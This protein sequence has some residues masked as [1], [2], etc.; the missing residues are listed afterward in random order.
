MTHWLFAVCRIHDTAHLNPGIHLA[1]YNLGAH[2]NST[3][4]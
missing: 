1:T 3:T 2:N 4:Y